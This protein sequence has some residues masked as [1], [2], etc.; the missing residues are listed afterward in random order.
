VN[1]TTGRR[2]V[3][4]SNF[5]AVIDGRQHNTQVAETTKEKE[6]RKRE[7]RVRRKRRG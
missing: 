4:T 6:E 5:A 2:S 1:I 7:E 3:C